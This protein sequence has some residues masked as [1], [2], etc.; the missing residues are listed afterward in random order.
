MNSSYL[1]TRAYHFRSFFSVFFLERSARERT[2]VVTALQSSLLLSLLCAL[3]W[4]L[5]IAGS[6][7]VAEVWSVEV[8]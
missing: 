6:E 1:V 4:S 7:L 2:W 8:E 3:D 5:E